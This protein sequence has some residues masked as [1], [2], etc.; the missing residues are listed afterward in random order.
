MTTII[1]TDTHFG[2]KQ[3]SMTW[4]NSQLD[5]I[6]NQLIPHIKSTK[7]VIRLV[8][9]GDVFDSR[10]SISTYVASK[11]YDVFKQLSSMVEEFIIVDGNHDYYSPNSEDVDTVS[12]MFRDLDINVIKTGY[13]IWGDDL[14]VPW[15]TWFDQQKLQDLIDKHNIKTV[16]THADIVMSKIDIK[17]VDIYSGHTHIPYIKGRIKNLGSCYALNFGDSNQPRGFYEL[18]NEGLKFIENMK[19]IRFY[20]LYNDDIFKSWEFQPNDYIEI[21]ITQS[22]LASPKYNDRINHFTKTYKNTWVIP[23]VNVL[24]VNDNVTFEGYDIA[25]IAKNLIPENLKQKFEMV[26]NNIKD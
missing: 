1:F 13:Y 2:V 15:F 5:F 12:L 7:D 11:V 17:G 26:I 4:L 19:S 21:Y 6:N 25:A 18:T 14:F 24:D 20:R 23:Q 22:N 10:S 8:H 16:Y 3:N 9:L